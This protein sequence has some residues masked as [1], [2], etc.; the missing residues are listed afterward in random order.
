MVTRIGLASSLGW[1]KLILDRFLEAACSHP[2]FPSPFIGLGIGE[3]Q[4]YLVDL[5]AKVA[6]AHGADA[7]YQASLRLVFASAVIAIWFFGVPSFFF[8][9]YRT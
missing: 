6:V 3:I 8:L 1:I 5:S 2:D 7:I 9:C 4:N